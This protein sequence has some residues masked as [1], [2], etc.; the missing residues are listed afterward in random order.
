MVE[1]THPVCQNDLELEHKHDD[2]RKG[3][4]R[5]IERRIGNKNKRHL[6]LGIRRRSRHRDEKNGERQ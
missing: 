3:N 1:T 5:R 2:N 4:Y 6:H